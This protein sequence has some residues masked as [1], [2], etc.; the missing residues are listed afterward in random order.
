MALR[1]WAAQTPPWDSTP[2]KTRLAHAIIHIS[3][4]GR[5]WACT[6]LFTIAWA[7]F[8]T[9]AIVLLMRAA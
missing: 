3:G 5:F 2:R 4:F 1:A 8:L 7:A 9:F 6:V